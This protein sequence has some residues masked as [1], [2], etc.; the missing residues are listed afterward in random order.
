MFS[1]PRKDKMTL[2]VIPHSQ[3]EVRELQLSLDWIRRGI[4]ALVGTLAAIIITV[5]ILSISYMHMAGNMSELN[6]L[7]TVNKTQAQMLDQLIQDTETLQTKMQEIEDLDSQ[8]RGMMGIKSTEKDRAENPS[9]SINTRDANS[10]NKSGELDQVTEIKQLQQETKTM[11]SQV[12]GQKE[13]LSSLQK[14][15]AYKKARQAATPSIVPTRGR[16]TGDYGWRTNPR[17]EF[18]KGIDIAAPKGTIVRAT[19]DGIVV[20]AGKKNGYGNAI[21]ISHGYGYKT[22]YGHNSELLVKN[23]QKVKKEEAI[24]KVGSTGYSTGNHCHYE[25][26]VNGT[27]VDPKKYY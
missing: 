10:K 17:R 27:P 23:G 16:F 6:E 1:G 11:L 9:R 18:H 14:T 21:I 19:A 2:M 15:I 24:A 25:V 4:Y 8:V 13:N 20:L 7:R 26:W 3:D 12:D 5:G 22:L